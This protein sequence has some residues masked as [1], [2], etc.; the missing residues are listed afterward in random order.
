MFYFYCYA[1]LDILYLVRFGIQVGCTLGLK[2]LVAKVGRCEIC[3]WMGRGL[4]SQPP[5]DLQHSISFVRPVKQFSVKFQ[6]A[7]EDVVYSFVPRAKRV[8][9]ILSW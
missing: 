4:V 9:M 1:F 8:S 6:G 7:F 5:R 2:L 3:V